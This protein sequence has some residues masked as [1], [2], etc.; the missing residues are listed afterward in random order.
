VSYVPSQRL[1]QCKTRHPKVQFSVKV[2]TIFEDSPIALKSWLMAMWMIARAIGV[3]Q[4]SAWF[5]LRGIRLAMKISTPQ[6]MGVNAPVEV[7]ETFVGPKPQKMHSNRRMKLKTAASGDAGKTVV[8]G[9]LDPEA[10][11]VRAK[12]GSQREARDPTE[13]DSATD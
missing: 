7:D 8:M 13:R 9:M 11:E 5:M 10:R 4:K 1:W 12:V 6:K 3:T 2:G